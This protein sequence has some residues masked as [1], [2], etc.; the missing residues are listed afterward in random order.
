MA[1]RSG[2]YKSDKRKKEL[3]RQKKQEEKRLRRQNTAKLASQDTE[4]TGL[5]TTE[6]ESSVGT[7]EATDK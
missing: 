5:K 7:P 6:P 3:L 4:G 1:R 2:M